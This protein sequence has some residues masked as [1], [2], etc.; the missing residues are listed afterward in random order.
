VL[1]DASRAW[2]VSFNFG[3]QFNP[4]RIEIEAK[5]VKRLTNFSMK[6]RVP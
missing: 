5:I 4:I 2:K 3:K 6:I 1:D